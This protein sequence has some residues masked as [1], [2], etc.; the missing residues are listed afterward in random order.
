M[1]KWYA[2]PP[3]GACY[4]WDVHFFVV[5]ETSFTCICIE[6]LSVFVSMQVCTT[7]MVGIFNDVK[8][9][10][11]D[12][13]L[14]QPF[15]QLD[16][17]DRDRAIHHVNHAIDQT[18]TLTNNNFMPFNNITSLYHDIPLRTF[19]YYSKIVECR[20]NYNSILCNNQ[21]SCSS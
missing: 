8:Y 15:H 17:V 16:V 1:S 10:V 14:T 11:I 19:H 2:R 3:T 4:K 9:N 18:T 7:A 5:M 13:I 6:S 12:K 20:Y 21:R